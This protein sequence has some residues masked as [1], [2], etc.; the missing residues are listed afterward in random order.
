MR[1]VKGPFDGSSVTLREKIDIP[2]GTEVE[3]LI[4]ELTDTRLI[5]LLHD[6][7][8]QP[9]GDMLSLADVVAIVHEVRDAPV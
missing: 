8:Q 1:R 4:P 7:D 5:D 9:L 3:V 2:A 6:L